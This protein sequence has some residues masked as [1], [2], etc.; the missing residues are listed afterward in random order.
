MQLL[1][2][3]SISFGVHKRNNTKKSSNLSQPRIEPGIPV[4]KASAFTMTPYLASIKSEEFQIDIKL[5]QAITVIFHK[6][7]AGTIFLQG[8]Q[9]HGLVLLSE[10]HKVFIIKIVCMSS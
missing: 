4:W 9:M 3:N 2:A 10:F 5:M 8:L 6:R 1:V 7:P